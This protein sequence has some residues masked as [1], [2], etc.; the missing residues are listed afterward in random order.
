MVNN[1]KNNLKTPSNSQCSC[2][3]MAD[4]LSQT[5]T[6]CLSRKLPLVF[7]LGLVFYSVE[8]PF[9][10]LQSPVPDMA[11]HS[12]VFFCTSS[13]TENETRKKKSLT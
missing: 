1:D 8:Y 9:G 12:L 11:P 5:Q 3:L 10:Y 4:L 6:G 2:S 13:Q 7:I